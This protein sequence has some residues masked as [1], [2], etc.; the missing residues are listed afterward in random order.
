MNRGKKGK[1]TEKVMKKYEKS[2]TKYVKSTSKVQKVREIQYV[3]F[4][5]NKYK[6]NLLTNCILARRSSLG[7]LPGGRHRT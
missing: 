4:I 1:S 3:Q 2:T 7:P 6:K 5:E